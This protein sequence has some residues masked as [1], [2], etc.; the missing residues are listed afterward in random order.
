M[1]KKKRRKIILKKSKLRSRRRRSINKFKKNSSSNKK[2]FST[3][4]RI[5]LLTFIIFIIYIS[6]FSNYFNIKQII[7]LDKN[8][9]N[10]VL[11]KKI[12]NSLKKQIN[13]NLIF[14]NLEKLEKTIS[15]D[16]PEL[17]EI[18]LDKD[19]PNKL[20]I[21]FKEFPLIANVINESAK[22]KKSFVINSIGYAIKENVEKPNLLY[23][24]LKSENPINPQMPVI[25][26]N[27][28]LYIVDAVTLFE[29]KFGMKIT[30]VEYKPIARELHLLT[31]KNFYIWLDIQQ[32]A[33]KQFKKL[34]KSITKLDIYNENLEYIDLR[35]AGNNGDKII[36]KRN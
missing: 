24:K 22:I 3:V 17:K 13:K 29:N 12:K 31:E 20:N 6:F 36:Y 26:T 14:I 9:E 30:E 15:K 18:D 34:K 28:L 4:K 35:I 25:E 32:S 7:I 27:K 33:D 11:T 10:E 8:I 2:M 16:F 21:K 5:L 23:I 1:F 19:Y